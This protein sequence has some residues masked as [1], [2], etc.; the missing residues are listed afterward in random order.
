MTITEISLIVIASVLTVK[1]IIVS[2]VLIRSYTI[3]KRELPPLAGKANGVLDNLSS[4]TDRALEQVEEIQ[5]V[6][7]DISFKT[8]EVTHEVQQKIMPTIQDVSSAI[9]G[10][11]RI[12]AFFFNRKK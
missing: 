11:A 7:N 12:L 5:M 2:V 3:L 9:S 1:A 8:R 10:V 6:V 4:V